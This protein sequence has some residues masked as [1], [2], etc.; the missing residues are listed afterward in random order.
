[1]AIIS[2]TALAELIG[3]SLQKKIPKRT[4]LVALCLVTIITF[5]FPYVDIYITDSNIIPTEEYQIKM[6]GGNDEIDKITDNDLSSYIDI[7]QLKQPIEINFQETTKVS[8]IRFNLMNDAERY[9]PKEITLKILNKE[10][11]WVEPPVLKSRRQNH[12]WILSFEQQ[13]TKHIRVIPRSLDR[14]K[15]ITY[16]FR[17][18]ELNCLT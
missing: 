7:I 8:E 16:P 4:G 12:I 14:Y 13:T 10:G 17:I 18:Y 9:F 15:G 1:L 2:L 3:L 5:I 6:K 11:R